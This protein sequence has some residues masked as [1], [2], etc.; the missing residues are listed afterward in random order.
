MFLTSPH[1]NADPSLAELLEFSARALTRKRV[2]RRQAVGTTPAVRLPDGDVALARVEPGSRLAPLPELPIVPPVETPTLAPL[3]DRD[4]K[5]L[6]DW[7]AVKN[8]DEIEADVLANLALLLPAPCWE[9][10][11][12]SADAADA[13]DFL[14]EYL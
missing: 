14:A 13:L 12:F 5:A 2:A 9:D 4:L 3:R 6:E 10:D 8:L 7:F 1:D 11:P